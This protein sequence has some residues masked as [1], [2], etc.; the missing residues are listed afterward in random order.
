MHF[1]HPVKAFV[2]FLRAMLSLLFAPF[3]PVFEMP[4][5][6]SHD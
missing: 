1:N 5:R 4:G 2:R 6:L 3:V